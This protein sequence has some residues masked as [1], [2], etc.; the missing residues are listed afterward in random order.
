MSVSYRVSGGAVK[1]SPGAPR[2]PSGGEFQP[3]VTPLL[4]GGGLDVAGTETNWMWGGTWRPDSDAVFNLR[5]LSPRP[6][7]PL[8]FLLL[9][10][11][12]GRPKRKTAGQSSYMISIIRHSEQFPGIV[13]NAKFQV[14]K[15]LS[16]DE[17]YE[18]SIKSFGLEDVYKLKK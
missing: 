16:M 2:G 9:A 18:M 6:C 17:D 14:M 15:V 11:I 4:E 1:S 13:K 10:K 12:E 5:T 8:S 7:H 3:M